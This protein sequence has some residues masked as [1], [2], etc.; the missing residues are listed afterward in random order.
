MSVRFCAMGERGGCIV[1]SPPADEAM[2][3]AA[4][5]AAFAIQVFFSQDLRFGLDKKAQ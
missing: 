2:R 4:S 1:V 5:Y 3:N